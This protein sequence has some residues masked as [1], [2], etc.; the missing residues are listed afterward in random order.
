MERWNGE[1]REGKWKWKYE[2]MGEEEELVSA[3]GKKG[4]E[5]KRREK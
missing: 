3:W 1:I 2:G 5:G 4:R